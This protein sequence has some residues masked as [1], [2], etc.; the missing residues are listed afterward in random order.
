MSERENPKDSRNINMDHKT[1][2]LVGGLVGGMFGGIGYGATR[3][4]ADSGLANRVGVGV[5][6]GLGAFMGGYMAGVGSHIEAEKLAVQGKVGNAIMKAWQA[7]LEAGTGTGISGALTGYEFW[8]T[9]GAVVGG[10]VG[11][12]LSTPTFLMLSKDL[13]TTGIVFRDIIHPA[14][15][16][17]NFPQFNVLK[18]PLSLEKDITVEHP[19]VYQAETIA[20]MQGFRQ[21]QVDEVIAKAPQMQKHFRIPE[22]VLSRMGP[23]IFIIR[24][25][26]HYPAFDPKENEVSFKGLIKDPNMSMQLVDASGDKIIVGPHPEPMR[27]IWPLQSEFAGTGGDFDENRWKYWRENSWKRAVVVLAERT[28]TRPK[29]NETTF[30]PLEAT[31]TYKLIDILVERPGRRNRIWKK[32]KAEKERAFV[33]AQEPTAI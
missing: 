11:A 28:T 17:K 30:G 5:G 26:A 21:A 20:D 31:D 12:V 4:L 3:L 29:I 18:D 23:A 19:P 22:V 15:D 27:S 33:P 9:Q 1:A 24:D 16:P 2:A 10:I 32:A 13:R 6:V 25:L 14:L 7:A 8:G